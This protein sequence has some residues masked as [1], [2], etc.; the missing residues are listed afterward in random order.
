MFSIDN[1]PMK[2]KFSENIKG[3]NS[4][5]PKYPNAKKGNTTK[6]KR[7]DGNQIEF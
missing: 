5:L 7:V 6:I 3:K 4:L 1:S 2:Q